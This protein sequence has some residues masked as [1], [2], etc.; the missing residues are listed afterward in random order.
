MASQDGGERPR[1][2]WRE[3]DKA[4]DRGGGRSGADERERARFEKSAEYARYKRGLERLFSGKEAPPELRAKLD[5]A[6]EGAA[7]DEVLRKVRTAGDRRTWAAAIEELWARFGLPDD[8]HLLDGALDHANAEV[9]QAALE[10]LQALQ[11]AGA[12]KPPPS[13]RVRLESLELSHDDP[14]VQ[15]RAR[16]L[17]RML[18]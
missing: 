15:E 10:K 12:L 3:I 16:A 1:R 13:L 2:P 6:S 11:D 9:V 8:A 7:R 17:R 5:P 18:R 4:R 14:E